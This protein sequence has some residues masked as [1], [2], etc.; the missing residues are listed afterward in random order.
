MDLTSHPI[1]F[2]EIMRGM[3]A[4]A[5]Q[6]LKTIV[7]VKERIKVTRNFSGHERELLRRV[8]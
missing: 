6:D 8:C 2:H 5:R 3:S 4:E 1:W 7:E